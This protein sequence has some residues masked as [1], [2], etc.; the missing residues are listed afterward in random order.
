[1]L[2]R[3]PYYYQKAQTNENYRWACRRAL[4]YLPVGG[5]T[6]KTVREM[7]L[8]YLANGLHRNSV[9]VL[10]SALR[11]L[12]QYLYTDE[13]VTGSNPFAI[14]LDLPKQGKTRFE[15]LTPEQATA[16]LEDLTAAG[17]TEAVHAVLVVAN[18]AVRPKEL[19]ELRP[20]DYRD[21]GVWIRA[22]VAKTGVGRFVH[23]PPGVGYCAVHLPRVRRAVRAAFERQ[24]IAW[25]RGGSSLY[26]YKHTGARLVFER[27][28]SVEAV[29]RFCGHTSIQ[30]TESY[31]RNIVHHG[32]GG[33][34]YGNTAAQVWKLIQQVPDTATPATAGFGAGGLIMLAALAFFIIRQK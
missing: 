32:G 34:N 27:T 7:A 19:A 17:E 9:R 11:S 31:L 28:Q 15:P 1:M 16:V 30:S 5:Y 22:E 18:G 14:K 6:P 2:A 8:H 3:L 24:G 25:G 20:E 10:V 13:L 29:Q 26:S 4:D 23:L 21:G 33:S 12:W